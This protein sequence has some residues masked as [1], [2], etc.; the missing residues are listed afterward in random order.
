[1]LSVISDIVKSSLKNIFFPGNEGSDDEAEYGPPII[2]GT[3]Y[4]P[5]LSDSKL[6]EIPPSESG[7]AFY[8][9]L[10]GHASKRGC[11][12]YGNYL[13]NEDMQV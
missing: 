1:M 8:V 10:H 2:D 4:A 11:F 6:Q 3:T 7:I 13:E 12:I 9:D 5:H